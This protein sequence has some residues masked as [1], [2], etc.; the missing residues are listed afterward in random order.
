[1]HG[2]HKMNSFSSPVYDEP[3]RWIQKCREDNLS[4]DQ[5]RCARRNSES[6]L[7]Q[8]LSIKRYDDRWPVITV[9]EWSALVTEMEEYEESQQS[10]EFSGHEGALFDT[11]QDNGL[12]VPENPRSCWQ[13]YRKSLGWKKDS[14]E[15]LE[16]ASIG[17]LRRLSNDT[18]NIGPIKGLVIGHVQSGKTANIE[19]LMA[20]E[21]SA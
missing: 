13:L 11:R 16:K 6:E 19:G 18:R 10:L 9:L 21:Y 8:F 14:V 12:K 3:R 4:W 15:E 17:I 7:E 1:M 5:I 2:G 20:I